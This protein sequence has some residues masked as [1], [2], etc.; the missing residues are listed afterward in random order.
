MSILSRRR[1]AAAL[2]I[3]L[4][5]TVA[6]AVAVAEGSASADTGAAC[7]AS[8][9]IGWQTPS[10]NPPDF[11]VTVTVTNNATY[12][13]TGW[14]V[15]WSYTA[16]QAIIAGSPYSANVTQTG[17]TVAATPM[18]SYNANLAPGASTTW[19]FHGTYNGTSNPV[20]TVTC[21]GPSQGS[22]SATLAGNLSPLGINTASWDTNFVDPEIATYLSTANAGLILDQ[23]QKTKGFTG[24]ERR[25]GDLLCVNPISGTRGGAA[26]A[27]GNP[28]TL[29][30]SAD[31][32]SAKLQPGIVGAH[33]D[34]GL[35]I[36]SGQIPPL[37]PF[38]LPGNNYHVYDY[39]LFWGA[40]RRDAE[41]RLEAWR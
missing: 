14:T 29:V 13:I 26:P 28:G 1:G 10:N 6:A 27:E 32:R 21:T 22:A 15:T 8:Y 23:W 5:S 9:V 11:G 19:G 39:A 18:G 37:G 30:P 7:S 35:L 31:L 12:A 3:A 33:C 25:R 2:A 41:R 4:T 38:V 36:V 24:G 34:E 40:I 17:T 16:G 20:P